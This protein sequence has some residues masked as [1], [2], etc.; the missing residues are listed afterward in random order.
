MTD[1]ASSPA[2]WPFGP[3]VTIVDI[4]A[5]ELRFREPLEKLLANPVVPMSLERIEKKNHGLSGRVVVVCEVGL[6]SNVAAMYLRADGLDAEHL[7]GG[8]RALRRDS[9]T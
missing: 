2:A 5:Q 9:L 4:R 8:A 6:R 7:P 1:P 3:D